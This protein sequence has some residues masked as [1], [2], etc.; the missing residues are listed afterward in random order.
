MQLKEVV[1]I[2][3]GSAC[4]TAKVEP[5]HVILALGYGEERAHQS[6]RFGLGRSN[7]RDQV[8]FVIDRI[9]QVVRNLQAITLA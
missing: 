3:T 9:S 5:S 4:S 7:T 2:S 1:A 8:D 6:V